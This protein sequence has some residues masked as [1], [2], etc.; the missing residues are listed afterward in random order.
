MNTRPVI[1]RRDGA[2]GLVDTKVIPQIIMAQ[3]QKLFAGHAVVGR[4]AKATLKEEKTI[5]ELKKGVSFRVL[6]HHTEELVVGVGRTN[7]VED[8][9]VEFDKGYCVHGNFVGL[10]IRVARQ[11]IGSGIGDTRDMVNLSIKLRECLVPA[12][13]RRGQLFLSLPVGQRAMVRKNI[14]F[15]ACK[16]GFELL[17]TIDDSQHLFVVRWVVLLR[18]VESA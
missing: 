1:I 12:D 5:I 10:D 4:D 17:Q 2:P 9:S 14:E 11:G 15:D 8:L 13:L 18:R 3:R 16:V 6:N 7:I